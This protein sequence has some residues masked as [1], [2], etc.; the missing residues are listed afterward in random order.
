MKIEDVSLSHVAVAVTAL[1]LINWAALQFVVLPTMQ[2]EQRKRLYA[3]WPSTPYP[4]VISCAFVLFAVWFVFFYQGRFARINDEL[5]S[6][7]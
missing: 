3:G 2:E 5:P 1:G 4:Y 7:R 6:L